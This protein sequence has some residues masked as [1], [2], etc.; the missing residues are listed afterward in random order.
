MAKFIALG[1]TSSDFGTHSIQK[2]AATYVATGCT[3]SPS[4]SSIC[5]RTNW[6]LGGVKDR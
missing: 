6:T 5:L 2:G 4:M 1:V 3:V